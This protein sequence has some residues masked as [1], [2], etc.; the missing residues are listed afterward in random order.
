M[1]IKT[2]NRVIAKKHAEWVASITDASLRKDV[3]ANSIVTG[4][5]IVS[6]LQGDKVNDYDIYFTNQGTAK[7][8]AEYYMELANAEF[9]C[10]ATLDEKLLEEGRV[11][12]RIPSA[13][14]A[15]ET[16]IDDEEDMN[17]EEIDKEEEEEA[18]L[19]PYH[20][21]HMSENAITL[22][23]RVQ[24]VIRFYGDPKEI[25][26]NYDFIHCTNYW[27]HESGL[28]TNAAALEAIIT[29]ELRYV[30]SLYP[31]CSIIRT[32][33][34]IGRGWRIH[35]GQY[36]KMCF[37]LNELDLKNINVLRDQ[38][39]GVD[40]AYFHRLIAVMETKQEDDPDFNFTA[41]YV[42]ELIDRIFD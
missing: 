8:V 6:L 27:T 1:K 28:V 15:G 11:S 42:C 16:Q 35:A 39:T 9:K 12:I 31:L 14:V 24:L 30:G 32:R 2:I 10:G 13:G 7:A 34:F 19:P 21:I 38:L 23:N 25:H 37:Q 17:V 22:S 4:G 18:K 26:K 20:P 3:K 36:L 41:T 33:K 29:K 5:C 40:A